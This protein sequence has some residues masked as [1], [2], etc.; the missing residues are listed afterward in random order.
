M[1]DAGVQ[2]AADFEFSAAPRLKKKQRKKTKMNALR[3][4]FESPFEPHLKNVH[5]NYKPSL[6]EPEVVKKSVARMYAQHIQTLRSQESSSAFYL[7]VYDYFLAN[8]EEPLLS[9][10]NLVDFLASMIRLANKDVGMFLFGRIVGVIEPALSEEEETFFIECLSRIMTVSSFIELAN[11]TRW[12]SADDAAS[13]LKATFILDGQESI[14]T[15]LQKEINAL[16]SIVT[17]HDR[18]EATEMINI[19]DF[20]TSIMREWEQYANRARKRFEDL[21]YAGDANG[22]R[23][24]SFEEF[25]V[26]IR[27]CDEDRSAME[28]SKMYR[29]AVSGS[30]EADDANGDDDDDGEDPAMLPHVFAEVA[31]VHNLAPHLSLVDDASGI[32]FKKRLRGFTVLGKK[33][34]PIKDDVTYA[35][36]N[37]ASRPWLAE[38]ERAALQKY[39]PHK[40]RLERFTTLLQ[41]KLNI[42]AAWDA[43]RIMMAEV[44]REE[45]FVDD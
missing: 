16:K 14:I 43:F 44:K 23:R 22:D 27:S 20:L 28:I 37:V 9:E 32:P 7:F 35:I 31:R 4:I 26:I 45:L 34:N 11:A 19:D 25:S 18:S 21:F 40:D 10:M 17:R 6:L 15:R 3:A 30:L 13:V 8:F 5:R 1:K 24:L 29:S 33:W 42:V 38:S 36:R 2:T 41:E 39:N 12:I